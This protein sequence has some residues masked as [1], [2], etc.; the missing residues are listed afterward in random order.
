MMRFC[1]Q[2]GTERTPGTRFCTECGASLEDASS[3]DGTPTPNVQVLTAAAATAGSRREWDMLQEQWWIAGSF[4]VESGYGAIGTRYF[5]TCECYTRPSDGTT[6]PACGRAP[7]S[8]GTFPTGQ[9]DGVYPVFVLQDAAGSAT[10]VLACFTEEWALGVERNEK[11]P[12]SIRDIATPVR[13]G[14][15]DSSGMLLFNEAS[16]GWDDRNVTVDVQV[17]AGR[18]ELIAWLADVP[19][20]VQHGMQPYRRPI[21]VGLYGSDLVTALDQLT[22]VDRSAGAFDEYRPWNSMMWQVMSHR[23]PRWRDAARYNHHDDSARGAHERAAS[24]L[25]Q[26]AIHGDAD[27]AASVGP[28]LDAT[29]PSDVATRTRLLTMRGQGAPVPDSDVDEALVHRAMSWDETVRESARRTIID[30]CNVPAMIACAELAQRAGDHADTE[31]WWLEVATAPPPAGDREITAGVIGLC[32]HV[33]LP[34]GR[35]EEAE[36]YCR[37]LLTRPSTKAVQEGR[38]ML[39]RI[40]TDRRRAGG[41]RVVH[42]GGWRRVD[43]TQPMAPTRDQQAHFDRLVAYLDSTDEDGHMKALVSAPRDDF[44]PYVTGW[45]IGFSH[46]QGATATGVTRETGAQAL[47]AWLTDRGCVQLGPAVS[48]QGRPAGGPSGRGGLP[49]TSGGL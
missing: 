49:K 26:A 15:I 38:N 2:C 13:V 12:A 40:D 5:A 17:P 16:T 6:C 25:L 19:I 39:D 11:A 33:L 9:G 28:L 35:W 1:T 34:Q 45:L 41:A 44:L 14:V 47:C 23:E 18:Y 29:N 21:A 46:S 32:T 37:H 10:G 42:A 24:W 3:L 48:P 4:N 8:A 7:T 22:R 30:A 31:F 43:L 27:A 20:L 36:L